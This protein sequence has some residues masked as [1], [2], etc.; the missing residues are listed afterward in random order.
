MKDKKKIEQMMQEGK[1]DFIDP[2]SG[3]KYSLCAF[4]PND[5]HECSVSNFESASGKELKILRVA[6]Y[7]PI[8]NHRFDG[9]PENMFLR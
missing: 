8:C 6:F 7:C 3:Y 1:I 9:W 4:C 2:E 5:N